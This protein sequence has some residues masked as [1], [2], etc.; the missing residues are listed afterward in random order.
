MDDDADWRAASRAFLYSDLQQFDESS[1]PDQHPVQMNTIARHRYNAVNRLRF[2]DSFSSDAGPSIAMEGFEET[3]FTSEEDGLLLDVDKGKSSHRVEIV[4]ELHLESESPI[5]RRAGTLTF[6]VC[7]PDIVDTHNDLDDWHSTDL[8]L[9]CVVFVVSVK[10]D[11]RAADLWSCNEAVHV[12]RSPDCA[13][14]LQILL[15]L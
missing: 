8:P 15:V 11:H 3:S 14:M 12:E 9:S 10:Y 7:N 4:D 1:T 6:M 2:E 5:F 13:T